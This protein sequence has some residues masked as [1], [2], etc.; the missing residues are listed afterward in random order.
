[1]LKALGR[2]EAEAGEEFLKVVYMDLRRLAASKMARQ[3]QGH[4]LQPTALVHE[5]WMRLVD[6]E[7]RAQ[8]DNRAHFF[9]AAAEAMRRILVDH[10]RKK[11][12]EKRGGRAD[13]CD[14]DEIEIAAPTAN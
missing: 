7:G 6:S 1:L 2:G 5:A 10:A 8:F 13:H 14:L 3:S 11:F 12:S 9:A 4:T